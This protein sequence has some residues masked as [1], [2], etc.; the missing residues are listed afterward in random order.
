MVLD[1]QTG[2]SWQGG[3]T[4][5]GSGKGY[6][7]LRRP[8][9]SEVNFESDFDQI[10]ANYG[11]LGEMLTAR[12]SLAGLDDEVLHQL[13]DVAAAQLLRTPLIRASLQALPRDLFSDLAAHGF[14]IPAEDELPDENVVR[15]LTREAIADRADHALALLAKDFVLFEPSGAGR[16]WISDHPVV[17][18]SQAPLGD[19]GLKNLGVEIYLPI[20]SDLLLGFLCPSLRTMRADHHHPDGPQV[21]TMAQVVERGAPLRI[22]D[23]RVNFFNYLQVRDSQRFVYGAD[24]D[25]ALARELIAR[26]PA[27][28]SNR[29]MFSMGKMGEAPPR[30]ANIPPGEWLYLESNHDTLMIPIRGFTGAG[31]N[32]QMTTHRLDLLAEA[33][34]RDRFEQAQVFADTGG[35]MMRNAKVEH[36]EGADPGHFRL[37]FADLDLQNLDAAIAKSCRSRCAGRTGSN[38]GPDDDFDSRLRHPETGG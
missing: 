20:A 5:T 30:P 23:A 21:L 35:E 11:R 1:K 38:S 33:V 12:R 36:V 6:N 37:C 32:R 28:S 4:P 26:W 13:A 15:Q 29:T 9:G 17:R 3:M 19:T 18:F 27:L 34:G 22:D 8:D 2:R 24:D 31:F 10:D 25:F 7:T 14:A 16:F